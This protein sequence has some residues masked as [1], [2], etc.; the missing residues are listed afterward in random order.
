MIHGMWK[1]SVPASF[2]FFFILFFFLCSLLEHAVQ[3]LSLPHHCFRPEV[4]GIDVIWVMVLEGQATS[5]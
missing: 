1:V 2:D 5:P 3:P 4:R